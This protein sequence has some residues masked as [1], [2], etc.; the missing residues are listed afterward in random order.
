MEKGC[1][2]MGIKEIEKENKQKVLLLAK[3]DDFLTR[4]ITGSLL[5]TIFEAL[6]YNILQLQIK[7]Q[8][9]NVANR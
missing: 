4:V 8:R 5:P 3:F 1:T 9:S 2:R 6:I 7:I